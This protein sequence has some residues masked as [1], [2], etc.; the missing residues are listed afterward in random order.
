M[1]SQNTSSAIGALVEKGVACCLRDQEKHEEALLHFDA[2]RRFYELL[3]ASKKDRIPGEAREILQYLNKR[4]EDDF[5]E[6]RERK[7]ATRQSSRSATT[8]ETGAVENHLSTSAAHV[9][10]PHERPLHEESN[11]KAT[12]GTSAVSTAYA[13]KPCSVKTASKLRYYNATT[14]YKN[15]AVP[16]GFALIIN[17]YEFEPEPRHGTMEDERAIRLMLEGF[18]YTVE[19]FQD[20]TAKQMLKTAKEFA[21]KDHELSHSCIVV[22][23]THGHLNT[24]LGTDGSLVDIGQFIRYF[25]EAPSLIGKPK[26][27]IFQACRGD[28]RDYGVLHEVSDGALSWIRK[29]LS[30]RPVWIS[31][32]TKHI[33]KLPETADVLVASAAPTDYVSIRN[34][35]T[36]SWFI[37]TLCKVF[38]TYAADEDI[39]RLLTRVNREVSAKESATG[40]KQMPSC[41]HQ[42]R[43]DFYFMPGVNSE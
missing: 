29:F 27:F 30:D 20:L 28:R 16:K 9:G 24:L 42:L 40:Q 32:Q 12:Q 41:V 8:A 31:D 21:R 33:E 10:P 19:S 13:V 7:K 4:V 1:L 39:L 3:E 36:G 15:H 37:Q 6:Q 26:I 2:A 22:V 35:N 25:Q 14:V 17:N 38:S 34:K 11:T 43:K 23:L 18:G 5:K